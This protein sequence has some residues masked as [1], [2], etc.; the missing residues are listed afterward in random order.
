MGREPHPLHRQ[1]LER[2]DRRRAGRPHLGRRRGEVGGLSRDLCRAEVG[3]VGRLLQ[4]A[5][6]HEAV[7][8][9][10][11]GADRRPCRVGRGRDGILRHADPRLSVQSERRQAEVSAAR[12]RRGAAAAGHVHPEES[13]A[14]ECRQ[15]VGRFYPVGDRPER[16]GQGR[17]DGLRPRR[18]QEPVA[19]IRS[20]DRQSQADQGRLGEAVDDRAREAARRVEQ[21]VQSVI[22]TW[23]CRHSGGAAKRRARNP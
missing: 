18:V 17:G 3:I 8:S 21:R 2:R 14:S 7:V 20:G 9:G 5:R 15:A 16:A 11:L 19:R 10:A 13:P 22:S 12:G 6:R 1:V 23:S 4:E